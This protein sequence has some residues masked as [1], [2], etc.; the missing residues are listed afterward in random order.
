[1]AGRSLCLLAEAGFD[2]VYGARPLKREIQQMIENPLSQLILAN[3]FAAGDTVVARLDGENI[4]FA[5][6]AQ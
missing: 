1:M 3:K 4:R 2:S 6:K 5:K